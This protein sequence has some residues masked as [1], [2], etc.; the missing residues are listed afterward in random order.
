M[1]SPRR[2][3]SLF[4]W[5]LLFLGLPAGQAEAQKKRRSLDNN[6]RCVDLSD[7]KKALPLTVV[8]SKRILEANEAWEK[9]T[10]SP[11]QNRSS[12]G[13]PSLVRNDH[14]RK[15]DGKYYLY[16]AHHDPTSG[17]GCA[18]ADRIGGPYTKIKALDPAREHSM[19]LV[20]PHYPG[21]KGD[22][23]HFSSPCVAWCEEEKLWFLYFH[24]YNHYHGAWKGDPRSPGQGN[25]MTA[26][27]V[28]EDLAS[29]RWRIVRDEALGKVSV[30]EILPVLP[31]TKVPWMESESSYHAIQ[32]LPGGQWLA[33][34]RGTPVKGLPTLG[35]A[36][37]Q[38]GREWRWG[39]NN[40]ILHPDDGGK[41]Y[42]GIYRPGF[43][44]YLGKLRSGKRKYLLVWTE[45]PAAGD[46]PQPRYGYTTDFIKVVRDP[47]GHA[48][49]P[50]GDGLIS[51]WR[52]GARLYLFAGKELHVM[53][54][55]VSR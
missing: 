49:W 19:V 38:N 39:K 22:P 16:F 35:F 30:H 45:S 34:L 21:K 15:A 31:T 5:A 48:K 55:P 11:G 23:S 32:R 14:G 3:P 43:V 1:K 29:H 42:R 24:Y 47:R 7:L 36:T 40:P 18:V 25:Q 44:A 9:S 33:F 54:L 2:P 26:L 13:Y 27:A 53:K 10:W 8:S 6:L 37:S 41:G 52:E 50:A 28:S 12:L 46:V 17:I 51:A 4:L 20:N